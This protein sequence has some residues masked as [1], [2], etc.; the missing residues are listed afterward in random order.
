M[1]PGKRLQILRY[2]LGIKGTEFADLLGVDYN[3]LHNVENLNVRMNE[4]DLQAIYAA[5]PEVAS[6]V[7][8]GEPLEASKL[9]K[10][11]NILRTLPSRV[12]AGL[13]DK[14]FKSDWLVE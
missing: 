13:V 9:N 12:E 2:S 5:L 8:F 7:F 6:F 1:R 10:A 14:N 4:E 3:R 11:K